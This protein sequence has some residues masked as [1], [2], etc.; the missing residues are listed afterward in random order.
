MELTEQGWTN[1]QSSAARAHTHEPSTMVPRARRLLD[2]SRHNELVSMFKGAGAT[3]TPSTVH[4]WLIAEAREQADSGQAVAA[5]PTLRQIRYARE[6]AT[7]AA[8]TSDNTL[9]GVCREFADVVQDVWLVRQGR[10]GAC[11]MLATQSSLQHLANHGTSLAFIDGKHGLL[12]G[13]YQVVTLSIQVRGYGIPV[14]YFLTQ[15]S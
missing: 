1:V 13:G 6:R 10:A 9:A 7:A 2:A 14:A 8:H 5:S 11:V 15:R 12:E 3:L 4:R